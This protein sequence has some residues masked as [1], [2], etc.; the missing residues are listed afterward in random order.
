MVVSKSER[1]R[2]VIGVFRSEHSNPWLSLRAATVARAN[3][4]HRLGVQIAKPHTWL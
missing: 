2:L 3:S 1:G 4:G